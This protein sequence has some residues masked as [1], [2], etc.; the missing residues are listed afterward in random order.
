VETYP[1]KVLKHCFDHPI[2]PL[3]F[4]RLMTGLTRKGGDFISFDKLRTGLGDSPIL[5][6]KD[7]ARDF[8]SPASP[9]LSLY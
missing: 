7:W 2:V 8:V 4:G 1:G 6:W 9:F 3:V 5:P